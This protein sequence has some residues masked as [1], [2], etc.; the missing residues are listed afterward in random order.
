MN[1]PSLEVFSCSD[2]CWRDS[3]A[4]HKQSRRV[5]ENID[6]NFLIQVIE[7]STRRDYLLD[8]VLSNKEGLVDNVNLKGNFG[9]I[10]HE[11]VAFNILREAGRGK[12]KITTLD[13]RRG[14]RGLFRDL[15]GRVLS[16]EEGLK[17]NDECSR[18]TSSKLKRD[19]SQQTGSQAKMLG[20]L[21]G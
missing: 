7:G 5:L 20:G 19:P 14:D 13:F 2:I 10:D 9:S 3:T 8:L 12:S 6:D 17:K 4:G 1:V 16:W 15:L 11:M 21:H 18:I